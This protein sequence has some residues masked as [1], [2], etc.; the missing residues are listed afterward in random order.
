MIETGAVRKLHS[1]L[2]FRIVPV[3]KK[4]RTARLCVDF[5]E[6]NTITEQ[7]SYP[8]P[9]VDSIT[10]HLATLS[11]FTPLDCRRVSSNTDS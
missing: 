9:S 4:D 2:A 3:L 11:V 8:F 6:L 5:L 7:D 1:P 10:Y